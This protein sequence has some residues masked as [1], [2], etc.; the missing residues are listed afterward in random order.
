MTQAMDAYK[1]KYPDAP[2]PNAA[3]FRNVI[4]ARQNKDILPHIGCPTNMCR[5]LAMYG[6]CHGRE[7][8]AEHP[9]ARPTE[10]TDEK[11]FELWKKAVANTGR[12][13]P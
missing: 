4:N 10:C 3:T 12:T 6:R 2:F 11:C 7:C 9:A 8:W 5:K 1:T 13:V